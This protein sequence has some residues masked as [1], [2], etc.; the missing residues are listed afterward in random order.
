MP[1]KTLSAMQVTHWLAKLAEIS[2]ALKLAEDI[3]GISHP[4]WNQVWTAKIDA[5]VIH[6]QL[7]ALAVADVAVEPAPAWSGTLATLE[8]LQVV[9]D[10][11]RAIEAV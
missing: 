6:S 5:H 8:S 9:I 11:S 7:L 3:P 10:H 1:H 4:Q 2:A